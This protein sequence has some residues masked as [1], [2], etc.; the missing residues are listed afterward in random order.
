MII[1]NPIIGTSLHAIGG[2]SAS[3]CYTPSHKLK[4]WSWGTFWLVQS[5][6]AWILMPAIIGYF[7]V[8]DF[9]NILA[10]APSKALWGAFI[11]GA[12]YGFGGMS[13][14]LAIKHIGYSLTYTIAI[15]ISAVLGT[16][17]PLSILGGL[18]SYFTRPGAGIVL[19]GMIISIIGVV[20]CGWAGFRKE[21]DLK[22]Q[23]NDKPTFNMSIGLMLAIVAGILS[24]VFNISLELGQ[25]ISD[26]AAQ[27]G[28]GHF[29]GNAKIIV[30]TAGCFIVNFIWFLVLGI[31]QK[32][33]KE[34]T[35]KSGIPTSVRL[36]NTLWSALAG[37]LWFLQFFFYGLGH[38]KMGNFQFVSW[39]LHMS[40]LI[41]FSYMVG[42]L[43]K[44]W[45][46]VS[47]KT[48]L[49]LIIA[50]LIL[51]TSFII[52]GY[53]SYIGEAAMANV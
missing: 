10:N 32:T 14:G 37:S 41:F 27:K 28:A 13:F 26:I 7:T 6:F 1:P 45:K 8:P 52:T 35:S 23:T 47:K 46:N 30:S 25:P 18:E 29:E 2:I 48:Y 15:G 11:L 21:Q 31:R 39:A 43:M 49:L 53:G 19:I 50:L 16:I 20:L 22:S 34:Y 4:S 9:F 33:L 3:V 5:V 42:V 24:G 44:E 12:A 17:L 38:V 51:V 40:M 36:R